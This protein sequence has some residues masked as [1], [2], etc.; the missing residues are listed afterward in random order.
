MNTY[1]IPC[2][3]F[4]WQ[5]VYNMKQYMSYFVIALRQWHK[6]CRLKILQKQMACLCKFSNPVALK[7]QSIMGWNFDLMRPFKMAS[8]KWTDF[9]VTIRFLHVQ[10]CILQTM[11]IKPYDKKIVQE[12]ASNQFLIA[13]LVHLN[14]Y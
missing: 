12:M 13:N 3:H 6:E 10:I 2:T 14:L 8:N 1:N 4:D 9:H 5:L 7:L 11:Y